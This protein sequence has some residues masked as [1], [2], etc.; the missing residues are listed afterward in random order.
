MSSSQRFNPE[1]GIMT[2]EAVKD[3]LDKEIARTSPLSAAALAVMR[4]GLMIL[5]PFCS[6]L[7]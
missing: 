6:K 7:T 4:F 2:E 3:I 1:T 5:L